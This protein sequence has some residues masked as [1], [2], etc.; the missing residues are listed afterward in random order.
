MACN[1]LSAY[2]DFNIQFDIFT[3]DS[4]L[5]LTEFLI[6]AIKHISLYSINWTDLKKVI[7]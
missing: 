6:Q 7:Q 1:T 4:H 5:Q 2:L 3:N